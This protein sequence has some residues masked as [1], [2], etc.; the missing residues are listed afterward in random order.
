MFRIALILWSS[1]VL[2][3]AAAPNDTPDRVERRLGD[4]YFA[5]GK[6]I[7]VA[8]PVEGDLLAAG[9]DI[10][11]DA[12]VGGDTVVAGGVVRSRGKITDTL[13]AAGGRLYV[14]GEI[15]RNARI[16]GRA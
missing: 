7:S 10:T 5:T 6:T 1:A 13:Y 16:A 8:S 9:R 3:A 12:A 15:Q 14:D 2:S 4:D 11:I